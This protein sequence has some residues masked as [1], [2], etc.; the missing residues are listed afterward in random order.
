MLHYENMVVEGGKSPVQQ[1]VLYSFDLIPSSGVITS[2]LAFSGCLVFC[3]RAGISWIRRAATNLT[4][5]P[6]IYNAKRLMNWLYS[7]TSILVVPLIFYALLIVVAQVHAARH[8]LV[9]VP[10]VCVLAA[11]AVDAILKL[12]RGAAPLVRGAGTVA[13]LALMTAQLVDGFVTDK[14]Y[15]ADIRTDLANFLDTNGY[16]RRTETFISYT[17]LKEVSILPLF[18]DR[19]PTAAVLITCDIEYERY[20]SAGKGIPTY[21][22]FGGAGRT[23][24]YVSLFNG[25]TDYVP[26]FRVRR[27]PESFEDRLAYAGLLPPLEYFVPNECYAFN[28]R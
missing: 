1:I 4:R 19:T 2:I 3:S 5:R 10:V 11:I 24:F 22:V 17:H 28:K 16:T 25:T 6:I 23:K 15:A 7:P 13:I 20:L 12:L 14:I 21:H 27:E 9:F 8:V 18:S 26:I